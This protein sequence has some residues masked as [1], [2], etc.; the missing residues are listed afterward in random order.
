MHFH[1]IILSIIC[2]ECR[3]W[4][5]R[6]SYCYSECWNAECCILYCYAENG[7][8]ERRIFLLTCWVSHFLIVM[9][10]FAF[11]IVIP[12]RVPFLIVTMLS[13]IMLNVVRLSVMALAKQLTT[14]FQF[15]CFLKYSAKEN[16]N[17]ILNFT[18]K[19]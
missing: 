2:A 3:S 13:V 17:W 6:F 10:S 1:I 19:M 18:W 12:L 9:L 8:V 5:S 7:N 15:W 11:F 14:I 16:F 4:V